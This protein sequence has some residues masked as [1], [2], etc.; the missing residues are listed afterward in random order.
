M[1]PYNIGFFSYLGEI[2][3]LTIFIN[4]IYIIF[5]M[6]S[7]IYNQP[8]LRAVTECSVQYR[9]KDIFTRMLNCP[10]E[11]VGSLS[12]AFYRIFGRFYRSFKRIFKMMSIF[13]ST[14]T[15][16]LFHVVS[17]LLTMVALTLWIRIIVSSYD[18]R[19][20]VDYMLKKK[21]GDEER[22]IFVLM[23]ELASYITYY[24]KI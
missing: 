10:V 14:K 23:R 1:H 17:I 2:I 11:E 9:D 6:F 16:Y 22:E 15:L 5:K 12:E 4:F 18:T 20:R 7:D 8:K 21:T 13:A 3:W 24:R 19:L